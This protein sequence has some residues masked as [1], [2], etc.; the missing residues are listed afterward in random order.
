[1]PKNYDD[2]LLSSGSPEARTAVDPDAIHPMA[3][4]PNSGSSKRWKQ[5]LINA[6]FALEARGRRLLDL[7]NNRA[8]CKDAEQTALDE[9]RIGR[10]TPVGTGCTNGVLDNR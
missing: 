6:R 2:R 8:V 5:P 1:M 9:L 7:Q 3:V 4:W 10:R